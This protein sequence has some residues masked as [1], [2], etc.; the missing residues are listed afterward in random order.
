MKKAG[1]GLPQHSW[2]F[3]SRHETASKVMSHFVPPKT[4]GND[5]GYFHRLSLAGY[6]QSTERMRVGN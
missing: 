6:S 3:P 1:L 4:R 5:F 2:P